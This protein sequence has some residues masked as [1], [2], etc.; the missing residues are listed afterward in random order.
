MGKVHFTEHKPEFI[1]FNDF[2]TVIIPSFSIFSLIFRFNSKLSE[3][4]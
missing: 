3:K 4:L 2:L 1:N